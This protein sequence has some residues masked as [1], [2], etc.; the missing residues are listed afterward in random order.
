MRPAH[1]LTVGEVFRMSS[2]SP[3]PKFCCTPRTMYCTV[4]RVDSDP[5]EKQ[6]HPTAMALHFEA[7]GVGRF[8]CPC[9]EQIDVVDSQRISTSATP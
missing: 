9:E 7:G 8:L 4:V 6:Q 2:P 5:P 1:T 3:F